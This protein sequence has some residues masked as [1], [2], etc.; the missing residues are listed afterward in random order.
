VP[1]VSR[2]DT[3]TLLHVAGAVSAGKLLI[4][5]DRNLPLKQAAAG[6]RHCLLEELNRKMLLSPW[7]SRKAV[8]SAAISRLSRLSAPY[9]SRS[10]PHMA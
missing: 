10:P 2:Q 3:K 1:L 4:P 9:Q 7:R 6:A 8:T 5:I